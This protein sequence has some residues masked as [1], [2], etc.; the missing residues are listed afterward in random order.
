MKCIRF[1]FVVSGLLAFAQDGSAAPFRFDDASTEIQ[2][3]VVSEI[4]NCLKGAQIALMHEPS[5][6]EDERHLPLITRALCRELGLREK[7]CVEVLKGDVS[8]GGYRRCYLYETA[9]LAQALPP[10]FDVFGPIAP[11]SSFCYF[12]EGT[13]SNPM[14]GK[15]VWVTGR[16]IWKYLPPYDPY[17]SYMDEF[18][19]LMLLTTETQLDMAR[20]KPDKWHPSEKTLT[21][22]LGLGYTNMV[23]R[24][25]M[26]KLKVEAAFSNRVFRMNEGCDFQVDYRLPET[27]G[28]SWRGLEPKERHM[29]RLKSIQAGNS[30]LIHLLSEEVSELVYLAYLVDG[31]DTNGYEVAVVRCPKILK[32]V[33]EIKTTFGKRLRQALTEGGMLAQSRSAAVRQQGITDAMLKSFFDSIVSTG[34]NVVFTFKKSGGRYRYTIGSQEP[35]VSRYGEVVPVPCDSEFTV[36]DRHLSLSFMPMRN[37]Q[38]AV[39]FSLTYK[40]DFRSMGA[41]VTTNAARLVSVSEPTGT[42]ARTTQATKDRCL[43]G[44]RLLPLTPQETLP[45]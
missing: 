33:T 2:E 39:S 5:N 42:M 31:G 16:M 18:V 4:T 26:Q 29:E 30:V 9:R 24:Q 27:L 40:K 19:H 32:P 23:A 20:L 44:L 21:G 6:Q 14:A 13:R 35:Q 36:C 1:A 7:Y 43:Y 12:D 34:T 8:V 41:S 3:F 38:G 28:L 17:Q 37:T 10:L 45:K 22:I 15:R 25:A 11:P